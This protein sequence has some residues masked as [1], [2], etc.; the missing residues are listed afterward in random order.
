M[1]ALRL[2]L[3]DPQLLEVHV[4]AVEHRALG[5]SP[6][7]RQTAEITELLRLDALALGRVELGVDVTAELRLGEAGGL[8]VSVDFLAN[9]VRCIPDG[10]LVR[11]LAVQVDVGDV[12]QRL[13]GLGGAGA[14]ATSTTRGRRAGSSSSNSIGLEFLSLL[15]IG[16]LNAQDFSLLE[17]GKSIE[18]Y[19]AARSAPRTRLLQELVQAVRICS[20]GFAEGLLGHDVGIQEL[21]DLGPHRSTARWCHVLEVISA[22][23]VIQVLRVSGNVL[24]QRGLCLAFLGGSFWSGGL[25][26]RLRLGGRCRRYILA[27]DNRYAGRCG[28]GCY[29]GKKLREAWVLGDISVDFLLR[30]RSIGSIADI[31]ESLTRRLFTLLATDRLR[32]AFAKAL[33]VAA[34][35]DM[36]GKQNSESGT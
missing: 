19:A 18:P 35:D 26:R 33:T 11:L 14:G 29:F 21:V 16:E 20:N 22:D 17:P 12:W 6:G 23:A 30:R 8:E 3:G 34:G 25:R 10:Y 36:A 2:A 27:V 32:T 1:L 13:C 15:D 7:S 9:F 5:A 31:L 24:L 4:R 28:L